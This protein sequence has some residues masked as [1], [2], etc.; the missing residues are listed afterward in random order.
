MQETPVDS[1]YGSSEEIPFAGVRFT[2]DLG[3]LNSLNSQMVVKIS[4]APEGS[5]CRWR[6]SIE[7]RRNARENPGFL[8]KHRSTISTLVFVV[9]LLCVVVGAIVLVTHFAT[10]DLRDKINALL[11]NRTALTGRGAGG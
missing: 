10:K 1:L 4:R 8:K 7:G 9:I 11:Q 5:P 2:N 6:V 3:S